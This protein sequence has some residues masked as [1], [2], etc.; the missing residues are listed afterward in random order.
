MT[1]YLLRALAREQ[2]G[3]FLSLSQV[4][5]NLG[6]LCLG[7]LISGPLVRQAGQL[8]PAILALLGEDGIALTLSLVSLFLLLPAPLIAMAFRD[9]GRLSPGWAALTAIHSLPVS[10]PIQFRSASAL[11]ALSDLPGWLALLWATAMVCLVSG[12]GLSLIL[13]AVPFL[14]LLLWCWHLALLAFDLAALRWLPPLLARRLPTMGVL[15]ISASLAW[16]GIL[17]AQAVEGRDPL[18]KAVFFWDRLSPLWDLAVWWPMSRLLIAIERYGVETE[19]VNAGFGVLA[20]GCGLTIWI[21]PWA[22]ARLHR[23]GCL[24]LVP[25]SRCPRSVA[26][27]TTGR[28]F[29]GLGLLH[30]PGTFELS[31]MAGSILAI[32][33]AGIMEPMVPRW[34]FSGLGPVLAAGL[35]V[36]L[37]IRAVAS[38]LQLRLPV[39]PADLM[40][41][42]AL[43]AAALVLMISMPPILFG[44]EFDS[45]QQELEVLLRGIGSIVLAAW[46][47]VSATAALQPSAS[48]VHGGAR[49][50]VLLAA[51]A[52]LVGTLSG[53]GTGQSWLLDLWGLGVPLIVT[54][55]L[56]QIGC[57]RIRWFLDPDP[58][59]RRGAEIDPAVWAVLGILALAPLLSASFPAWGLGSE[60]TGVMVTLGL[61]PVLL[62]GIAW[63]QKRPG[64]GS[65]G[66][67]RAGLLT[68]C[69]LVVLN[70]IY[71][72][73]GIRFGWFGGPSSSGT[74]EFMSYLS[75][76]PDRFLPAF[77]LLLIIVPLGEELFFRGLLY[78]ALGELH[79]RGTARVL[80]SCI[81][82]LFHP[83]AHGPFTIVLALAACALR[84]RYQG[85]LAPWLAHGISNGAVLLGG[86]AR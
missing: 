43:A 42:R 37:Q 33:A 60:V 70:L 13:L 67:I 8:E 1:L 16:Y 80:S 83:L 23:L 49:G 52:A 2:I 32:G 9:D 63:V 55:R 7:L 18:H 50:L 76:G 71:T 57:H 58:P 29:R 17:F 61:F 41:S 30:A 56:W 36:A 69:G 3:R 35:G 38:L 15:L 62:G 27:T 75:R 86:L 6:L 48:T 21:A 84:D 19:V 77:L 45:F 34:I 72:S 79:G 5:V 66:C 73:A 14:F 44:V 74:G 46:M 53:P 78:P 26:S 68:G 11:A 64:A 10:R 12:Q 20:L 51:L 39:R 28:L 31:F 24:S 81:F 59:P 22:L 65:E 4:A 40:A 85:V 54:A 25:V 82:A 47:G